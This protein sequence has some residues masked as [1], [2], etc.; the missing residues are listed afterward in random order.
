MLLAATSAIAGGVLY[1]RGILPGWVQAVGQLLPIAPVLDGLRAAVVT[2][3]GPLEL[4]QPLGRLAAIVALVGPLGLWLFLRM[5][6]RAREDG[7]LT[8][9]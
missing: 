4:G 8:S 3:K 7:S 9:F 5:V 6:A 1:P 2:G